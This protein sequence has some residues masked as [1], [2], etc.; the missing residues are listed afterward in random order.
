MPNFNEKTVWQR[1][2]HKVGTPIVGQLPNIQGGVNIDHS[3]LMNAFGCCTADSNVTQFYGSASEKH[4]Q[5]LLIDA[6]KSSPIYQ[7]VELVVPA[8]N[9][10]VFCIRY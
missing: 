7:D 10:V 1:T 5:R 2:D 9:S 3:N 4:L 8:N 6:S